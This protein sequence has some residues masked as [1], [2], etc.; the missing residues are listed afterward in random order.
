MNLRRYRQR[1][2][3]MNKENILKWFNNIQLE[4]VINK[5]VKE[6]SNQIKCGNLIDETIMHSTFGIINLIT[7]K[8][9]V[10]INFKNAK[11]PNTLKSELSECPVCFNDCYKKLICGHYL[12]D[13]CIKKWVNVYDSC[14]VCRNTNNHKIGYIFK[15]PIKAIKTLI[16]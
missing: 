7:K 8:N 6:Y 12:C 2:S 11:V 14:P 1:L 5:M 15:I 9:F 3:K 16:I 13:T 4:S 10:E